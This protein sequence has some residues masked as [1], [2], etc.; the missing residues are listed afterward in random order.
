MANEIIQKKVTELLSVC[1][2]HG[3]KT[4]YSLVD[5]ETLKDIACDDLAK[6]TV[7]AL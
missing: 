4:I 3:F 2:S 5:S 7:R 6:K 1:G